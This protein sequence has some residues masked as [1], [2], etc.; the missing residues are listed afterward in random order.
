MKQLKTDVAI[1]AGGTAG[2][3]AAITAA[4]NGVS[5]IVFEKSPRTGGAAN[6]AN[7]PFAVESRH[8]FERMY[9]LTREE[10]FKFHM[11]YTQWRVNARLVSEYY[12]KSADTIDW[13]EKMGIEIREINAH[14]P[15]SYYTFHIVKGTRE[16]VTGGPTGAGVHLMRTMTS[17]A[18][19]LGVQI[20]L[21]TPVTKIIKENNRIRG[22][23]ACNEKGEEIRADA[24]A[25]IIATG[26]FCDNPEWLKKYTGYEVEKNLFMPVIRGISGDGIR[27]AWEMDAAPS[28]MT[29]QLTCA[30]GVTPKAMHI[31]APVFT[32]ANLKVNLLGERFVNEEE[33][34]P[35]FVANAIAQQKNRTGFAI[36]DED[37]KNHYIRE[38]MDLPGGVY[39]KAENLDTEIIEAIKQG[40]NDIFVADSLE[41]LAAKAKINLDGL[42][43]TVDQYNTACE[44]RIDDIFHKSAKFLRPVKR[45][46]FY[47]FRTAVGAYG[48][49]G[50]IKINHRTEVLTKDD[51]VIPGLYAAGNDANTIYGGTYIFPLPGNTMGFALNSGRI[52]GENAAKFALSG[53]QAE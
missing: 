16:G 28:E 43:H 1:V 30:P 33:L 12:N 29:L 44:Q 38:G 24:T 36:F 37:T 8:Q 25:V 23:V 10:A 27:M 50:G 19:K 39:R 51:D 15:G 2:I 7:G 6:I 13:L 49:L 34:N 11:Q 52:A 46:K 45:P 5:V 4:E 48:T 31:T 22:V 18:Q 3:A 40:S 53:E 14:S 21:K 47:V 41:E 42:K 26:G 35:G 9:M 32:Q 20:F 17:R